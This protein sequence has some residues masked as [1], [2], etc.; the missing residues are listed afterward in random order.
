MRTS[1]ILLRAAAAGLILTAAIAI[2]V[3]LT[4]DLEDEQAQVLLSTL[5]LSL[6]GL[7]SAPSTLLLEER[8]DAGL[9]TVALVLVV[10]GAGMALVLIWS[11]WDDDPDGL[12]KAWGVVTILAV[13][14]AQV[15]ANRPRPGDSERTRTLRGAATLLAVTAAAMG[16]WAVLDDLDDDGGFFRALGVVLVLDVLALALAP[17]SR[18]MEREQAATG[19]GLALRPV[20][21]VQSSL[22]D[23]ATAPKQGAEGA[24]E[25]W[26]VLDGAV[27]AGLKG[28][29]PGVDLMVLT[30]LHRADRSTLRVHPRDDPSNPLTGVFATRSADRPNPI[31]IHPVTV[32]AVEGSRLKVSGLEAVDGTP[33][34][35]LKI[36][37]SIA[38]GVPGVA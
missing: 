6:Y 13:A 27:A 17:I 8:R 12:L 31:G 3:L 30:W 4:G 9:A 5:A 38:A 20:G 14:L 2:V 16:S 33:V 34:L 21:R 32:L 10:A 24:P 26:I 22:A 25:A 19:A 7:A 29:E 36:A 15:A 37:L 11:A 18:R 28:I 35:D 1:Q 23:P